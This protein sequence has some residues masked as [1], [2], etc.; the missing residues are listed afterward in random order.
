MSDWL[1]SK[2]NLRSGE[3]CANQD[4]PG[5]AKAVGQAFR[6]QRGDSDLEV[7]KE[8]CYALEAELDWL[9]PDN[10]QLRAENARLREVVEVAAAGV[11]T[12]CINPEGGSNIVVEG[13]DRFAHERDILPLLNAARAALDLDGQ[14]ERRAKALSDLAEMDADLLDIDPEVKP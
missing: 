5:L 12:F 9:R 7:W 14:K 10:A 4:C 13:G 6:T 1:C 11:E 8:V 3:N 2:C